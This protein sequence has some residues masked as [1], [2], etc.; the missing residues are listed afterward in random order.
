MSPGPTIGLIVNPI[1][2]MGGAVGL[3]GTD[4]P[5]VLTR[6][7][8]LGAIP[9][10]AARTR[11]AL[12]ALA[13]RCPAMRIVTPRGTMGGEVAAETGFDPVLLGQAVPNETSATDTVVAV[14]QMKVAEVDVILFA[15]GDGTARVIADEVTQETP[16]LGIPCGV[17]MH[18]GVFAT[19]PEAAGRLIADFAEDK[20]RVRFREVEILDVDEAATRRDLIAT[21][22]YGY[23]RV[24]FERRLVQSPKGGGP[25][26]DEDAAKA[27]GAELAAEMAPGTVYLI[28]P[29]TTMK[30]ITDVLG[31]EKTLLGVDAVLDGRI[32]GKD[33][34]DREIMALS[35][36]HE[37][38][39]FIGV[40]G[41]QGYVL[42]RGNQQISAGVI[43][44]VGFDGITIV[45]ST[46]KLLALPESRLLV[47]TGDPELDAC[48][49]GY[50]RVRTGPRRS[51]LMRLES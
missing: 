32:V 24:P 50:V 19:S 15:G 43:R 2:G 49:S 23:V 51:M 11:R 46:R 20:S 16:V 6:A 9:R 29:G 13:A 3:K 21:R 18:S 27:A 7:R 8:E 36:R 26:A 12:S 33:I 4:G 45:A 31:L 48:L 38:R 10:A 37:T 34:A 28:G 40:T 39:I 42:G 22:L 47:D 1:A 44:R 17:K 25:L 30:A 5:A 14:R 35:A 41:G